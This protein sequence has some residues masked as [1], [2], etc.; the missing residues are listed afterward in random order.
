MRRVNNCHTVS[1]TVVFVKCSYKWPSICLATVLVFHRLV[2][3]AGHYLPYGMILMSNTQL[4]CWISRLSFHA[5]EFHV[6]T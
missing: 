4:T 3:L 2:H 1:T 5:F 6:R